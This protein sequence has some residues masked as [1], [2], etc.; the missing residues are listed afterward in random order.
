MEDL[1]SK[2]N[3]KYLWFAGKDG[4]QVTSFDPRK[5]D[6]IGVKEEIGMY[7]NLEQYELL[8]KQNS[9]LKAQLEI[10]VEALKTSERVLDKIKFELYASVYTL[11]DDEFEKTFF[12]RDVAQQALDKISELTKDK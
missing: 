11:E 2:Y 1:K 9:R 7:V 10:A 4:W 5:D 6:A 8:E 12:I 3:L